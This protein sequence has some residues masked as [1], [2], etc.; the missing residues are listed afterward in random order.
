MGIK[1]LTE[2]KDSMFMKRVHSNREILMQQVGSPA[3]KTS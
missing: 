2:N 1:M 3:M